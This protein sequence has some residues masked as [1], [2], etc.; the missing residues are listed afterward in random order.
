MASDQNFVE[1]I[2]EQA[3]DAGSITYKKMFGEYGVYVDGKIVGL[4]C[5]NQLFIKPTE[6][7]RA[8][9]SKVV[10]AP[11]YPGAKP[12]FLIE[13]GLDDGEWLSNLFRV[14]AQALP[15]PKPKKA[16]PKPKSKTPRTK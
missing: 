16:K 13:E 12:S 15:A 4:V 8:L 9:I 10:E 1:Y 5:D 14:T 7:G 2:A 6:A 3:A 11:A